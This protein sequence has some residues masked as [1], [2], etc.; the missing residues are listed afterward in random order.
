MIECKGIDLPRINQAAL[1][2]KSASLS[3]RPN[4]AHMRPRVSPSGGRPSLMSQNDQAPG[5]GKSIKA[6]A[7]RAE[8]CHAWTQAI[9]SFSVNTP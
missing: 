3:Q 4:A 7:E 2:L 1:A 8:A 9:A 5:G 6:F